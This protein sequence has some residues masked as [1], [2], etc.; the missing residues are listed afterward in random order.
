ME[1]LNIESLLVEISP[2]NPGGDNLEYDNEFR[3]LEQCSREWAACKV[4]PSKSAGKEGDWK[5]AHERAVQLFGRTKDLRVAVFLT[6][7]LTVRKGLAG[8]CGSLHL[9]R[10]LLQKYWDTLHPLLDPQDGNDPTERINALQSLCHPQSVPDDLRRQPL[11]QVR[12]LGSYSWRDVL[13]ARGEL[14]PA[15]ESGAEEGG[16]EMP[17]L[18]LIKGA[19]LGM[20]FDDLNRIAGQAKDGIDQLAAIKAFV[21]ERVDPSESV[22]F[23]SLEQLLREMSAFLQERVAERAEALPGGGNGGGAHSP[24]DGPSAPAAQTA[25]VSGTIRSRRDVTAALEKIC[26]YYETQEPSSPLPLLLRRAQRLVDKSFV[27]IIQD[28]TPDGLKQVEQISGEEY[29]GP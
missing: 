7:A 1:P 10:S 23:T 18:D 5:A 8:F 17:N 9:L 15:E 2:E 6:Q 22:N 20:E 3:E 13:I 26:A 14:K 28:L 24:D 21:E 12:G 25:P 4:D 19:F 16:P 27:E 29:P 11:V